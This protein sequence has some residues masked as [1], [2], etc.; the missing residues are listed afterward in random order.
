M[1]TKP[2]LILQTGRPSSDVLRQCG[3]YDQM[4]V[5]MGALG[6]ASVRRVDAE[7]GERPE[8]PRAYAAVLVTGSDAFVTDRL[9]W[10]E[11]AAGWLRDALD[12]ELPVFAVCYGHQLLA[13]ALGGTVEDNPKGEE[14][15]THEIVLEPHAASDPL[16]AGLPPCFAAN[17][18]HR[19]TVTALPRG[20][21][22][23]AASSGDS[24]QILR[25]APTAW[26]T[27][28]HPEFD[29]ATMTASVA[30]ERARANP[31][32]RLARADDTPYARSILQRFIAK[33][34]A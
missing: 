8:A 20:A 17:L 28:F 21:T 26:S 34:L 29:G 3:D 30:H 1:T 14:L 33:A 7:R 2:I 4:F 18:A 19:Q 12:A 15:G 5:R 31:A 32:A 23:L 22:T 13:H 24:H 27:Q 10:S 16:L 9:P 25:Y 11:A 6:T